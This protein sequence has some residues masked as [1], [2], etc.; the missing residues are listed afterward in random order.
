MKRGIK[1]EIK[2]SWL[3]NEGRRE[4]D[5][6]RRKVKIVKFRIYDEL[7][8]GWEGKTNMMCRIMREMKDN[9]KANERRQKKRCK[10]WKRVDLK[11]KK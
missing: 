7:S 3:A 10:K 6:R 8:G 11:V 4:R 5:A 9:W 2:G 1:C